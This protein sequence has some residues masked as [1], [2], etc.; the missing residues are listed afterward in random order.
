[1]RPHTG[2]AFI[3]SSYGI[4]RHMQAVQAEL[5]LTNELATKVHTMLCT[6]RACKCAP[7]RNQLRASAH[8]LPRVEPW[9]NITSK[10]PP[11]SSPF[12]RVR[13]P[14]NSKLSV[15]EGKGGMG[16]I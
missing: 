15:V 12:W 3:L 5:C 6:I 4:L 2:K 7:E 13:E 14:G 8:A 1:M 16:A 10:S 9:G 11:S